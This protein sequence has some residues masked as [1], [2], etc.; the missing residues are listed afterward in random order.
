MPTTYHRLLRLRP[1][2]RDG[3]RG[4]A[5]PPF[6]AGRNDVLGRSTLT[7]RC[8]PCPQPERRSLGLAEAGGHQCP[9]LSLCSAPGWRYT[10]IVNNR[11]NASP[12]DPTNPSASAARKMAPP[13]D[14]P[15]SNHRNGAPRLRRLAKQSPHIPPK[16]S[17]RQCSQDQRHFTPKINHPDKPLCSCVLSAVPPK[18]AVSAP[19]MVSQ[20]N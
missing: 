11:Y 18:S 5:P 14:Q 7:P 2:W 9:S 13:C 6:V 15:N 1:H 20:P 17:V 8:L 12:T 10:L 3:R 19:P 16:P 4:P